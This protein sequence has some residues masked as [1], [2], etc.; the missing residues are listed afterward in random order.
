MGDFELSGRA[1]QAELNARGHCAFFFEAADNLVADRVDGVFE[2]KVF[3]RRDVEGDR[4][5]PFEVTDHRWA[6]AFFDF[7]ERTEW[8]GATAGGRDRRREQG[9]R[10]RQKLVAFGPTLARG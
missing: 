1:A 10:V 3:R 2:R 9:R 4:A 5:A 7:G 8:D 6:E